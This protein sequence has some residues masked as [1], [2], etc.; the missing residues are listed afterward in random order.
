MSCREVTQYDKHTSEP[1]VHMFI[2]FIILQN[3]E[4]FY[5]PY[6]TYFA[7]RNPAAIAPPNVG[8][9]FTG[10]F[11]VVEITNGFRGGGNSPPPS[12]SLGIESSSNGFGGLPSFSLF[13]CKTGSSCCDGFRVIFTLFTS[14][15]TPNFISFVASV[16]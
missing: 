10:F 13:V 4:N 12:F 7:I 3:Y 11:S 1:I 6:M 9:T 2:I 16:K 15:F 5:N 14:S 8:N